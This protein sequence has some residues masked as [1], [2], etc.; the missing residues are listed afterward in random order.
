MNEKIRSLHAEVEKFHPGSNVE[1]KLS[2]ELYKFRI[3][4]QG[5]TQWLYISRNFVDDHTV[6]EL[7]SQF[8][9]NDFASLFQNST[10]NRWVFW[11]EAGFFDVDD[12]FGRSHA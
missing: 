7:M 6:D 9:F 12:N 10:K 3:E 8:H 1:F 4:H 2:G 11:N 5:P